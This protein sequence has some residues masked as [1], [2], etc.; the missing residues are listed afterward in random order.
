MRPPRP[1]ANSTSARLEIWRALVKGVGERRRAAPAGVAAENC[2]PNATG[3]FQ[4]LTLRTRPLKR[5][6][7][8]VARW[9]AKASG[10]EE[11]V[12]RRAAARMRRRVLRVSAMKRVWW[13][14]FAV[15]GRAEGDVAD[16]GGGGQRH[17]RRKNSCAG[18]RVAQ[19]VEREHGRSAEGAAN[20][21]WFKRRLRGADGVL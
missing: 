17:T 11:R 18:P 7:G 16:R 2:R 4:R 10:A 1:R 3:R 5:K 8:D 13:M 9:A 20:P 21:V 14:G 12:V 15:R 19:R 6:L